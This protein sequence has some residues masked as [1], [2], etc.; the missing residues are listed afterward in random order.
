MAEVEIL[1]S[2][3]YLYHQIPMLRR[4]PFVSFLASVTKPLAVKAGDKWLHTQLFVLLKLSTPTTSF[5]SD[6]LLLDLSSSLP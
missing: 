3:Y 1:F 6:T 5:I 4:T 2:H